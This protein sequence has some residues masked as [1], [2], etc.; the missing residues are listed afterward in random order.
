[1]EITRYRQEN[2][3]TVSYV[4]T[5]SHHIHS[6]RTL[7]R[8]F[9]M[10]FG[11]HFEVLLTWKIWLKFCTKT[12]VKCK[13][14]EN[15]ANRS[16]HRAHVHG[17]THSHT[18]TFAHSPKLVKYAYYLIYSYCC[19]TFRLILLCLFY[20]ASATAAAVA[21]A[22]ATVVTAFIFVFMI[23][24]LIDKL[25]YLDW[26]VFCT[27]LQIDRLYTNM[28]VKINGFRP[29]FTRL[30]LWVERFFFSPF[31]ALCTYFSL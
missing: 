11:L 16:D 4:H 26:I 10:M 15:I 19:F 6:H 8:F 2:A 25:H 23:Y 7:L 20:S 9:P 1:M 12:I 21:A 30:L 27:Q 28:I 18:H 22:T 29:T 31:V 13:T 3:V 24:S 14:E 5:L 17:H